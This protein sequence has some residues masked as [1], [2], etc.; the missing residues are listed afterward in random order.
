MDRIQDWLLAFLVPIRPSQ[1]FARQ[2]INVV[3]SL[4]IFYLRQNLNFGRTRCIKDLRLEKVRRRPIS[5]LQVQ[6]VFLLLS[7]MILVQISI[8]SSHD[9][10]CIWHSCTFSTVDVFRVKTQMLLWDHEG[11]AELSPL[12]T[13]FL[14]SVAGTLSSLAAKLF[15]TLYVPF[16]IVI[17]GS[18][19]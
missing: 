6:Q 12:F 16:Q 3:G 13:A 4:R 7:L 11:F 15:K 10:C 5:K 18:E 9:L 2:S 19:V 8:G 1:I 14:Q 17:L